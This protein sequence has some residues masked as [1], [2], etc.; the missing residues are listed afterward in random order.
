MTTQ[1]PI[2]PLPAVGILILNYHQPA[3][4][5]ACVRRLLEQEGPGTRILWLENDADRTGDT[6]PAL[7]AESGLPWDR[8]DPGRDPLPAAG[9]IGYLSIPANLGYGGGNN[10]GLRFLHEHGVPYAWVMNNDTWLAQGSS[11]DLLAAAQARP[12]IGLWGATLRSPEGVAYSGA[13]LLLKDFSPHLILGP[14]AMEQDPLAYVSGCSLFFPMRLG[15][16]VGFLPEDYFLYYEDP[17]FSLEFRRRGFVLSVVPE[18]VINHEESLSTGRRSPLMEYYSRR[19]RWT[20]IARYFPEHLRC[21]RFKACYRFQSLLL[22]GAF[23]RAWVE[24]LA[25]KDAAAG[26]Q[27]PTSRGFVTRR[28]L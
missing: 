17:A 22:R 7:L 24:W 8:V 21:Q 4:T 11:A 15:A 6:A 28:L 27:G 9:R 19:N 12:D 2:A 23:K 20:F 3:A 10:V 13:T 18:V 5:L 26:L 16:E 1:V 14:Q 25:M